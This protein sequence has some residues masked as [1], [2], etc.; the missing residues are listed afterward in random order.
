MIKSIAAA[1]ALIVTL[2]GAAQQDG[3]RYRLLGKVNGAAVMATEATGPQNARRLDV[4]VATPGP[5][6]PG[7]ADNAEFGM[8]VD[9]AA[10]T[11]AID[12]AATFLGDNEQ[13]RVAA[14]TQPQAINAGS[15]N[16][17]I[18]TAACSATP[19]NPSWVTGHAKA[20]AFARSQ[21]K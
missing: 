16:E 11:A 3:T 12:G 21:T 7:G 15:T 19:A 17:L 10:H 6:L 13:N 20:R 8:I 1:A 9:C 14:K 2:T 18:Y 5:S 4:V